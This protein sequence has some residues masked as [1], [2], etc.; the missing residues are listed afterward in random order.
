MKLNINSKIPVIIAA[1]ILGILLGWLFFG[2]GSSN[3]EDTI[4]S[5]GE[6]A[7][8]S[9]WTCSMHP[10]IRQNEPGDC[11]ICGMDL[12]PLDEDE[13]GAEDLSLTM[14]KTAMKLADIRTA[15]VSKSDVIKNIRLTGK[16]QADERMIYTQSSHVPGRIEELKINFIGD[17]VSKGQ[18]LALVYS[19]EL[20]TAQ[21]ELLEAQK[22]KDE[23][24]QLFKAA[25]KKLHNWK[26]SDSEINSIL[27]T[28]EI[29]G[30]F[31]IKAD[32]AGYVTAKKVN[33]GDYVNRGEGIYQITDL[34]RV[35]V[36][37][38]VYES[39]MNWINKGDKVNYTVSSIP[40]EKFTGTI[41]YIDPVIDPKS[42]VA[43][44]RIEVSN[45]GLKLKP[46]MFVSAMI[47]TK[48]SNKT[49]NLA[50]PKSAVMWTGKRSI[51]YVK[52]ADENNMS[53]QMR[54]V[55]LGP[56]L[57]DS[58][59]ISEGLEEGEEIAVNGT[60]SIDAAA[61]LA[62]KPSMMSPEADE[63]AAAHDHGKMSGSDTKHK[64]L[65]VSN[66]AKQALEPLYSSYFA[67]KE[68]LAI[69]KLEK[70]QQSGT[71]MKSSLTKIK[72]S[73][74]TG[75]SHERWMD[76]DASLK[77]SLEHVSHYKSLDEIRKAFENV[78]KTMIAMTR[79]FDP[80]DNIVFVQHCP[81]AF[82]DKGADWL[83][84][85]KEIRNPYFGASMLKC[86]EIT[87]EIK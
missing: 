48:L 78:S 5:E 51:V 34:S 45:K 21:E 17:V 31:P 56:A 13:G 69:D 1:L 43:K 87:E 28:G 63:S 81:M 83:S 12:I 84:K 10:Q 52:K 20:V 79:T 4:H 36:M 22:I 44:A 76:F 82:N 41:S 61:Q 62:G 37:L 14:S 27:E 9:V 30:I 75:E 39:D 8:E 42:R 15:V 46:E 55:T 24:P 77:K 18:T 73:L 2:G 57:G 64:K 25:K 35:W 11:P 40:S 58:Y 86:G 67:M 38:D 59:L 53:F 26:I 70:A 65:S 33:L 80:L 85:N 72:M 32:V 19:P 23:Q 50:I 71:K 16:V 6:T 66:D 60:F 68:A 54:E 74:F 3:E 47:E 49:N 7:Q 29:N